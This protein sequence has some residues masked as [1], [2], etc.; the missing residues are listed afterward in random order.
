MKKIIFL[1]IT[2][3]PMLSLSQA[4][5]EIRGF[6]FDAESGMP[7]LGAN[8]IVEGVENG[9]VSNENGFFEILNIKPKT[10]NLIVS[11]VG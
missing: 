3:I 2:F 5:G 4:K 6:I 1:I 10:Y 8:I 11:Y 9:A 7:L